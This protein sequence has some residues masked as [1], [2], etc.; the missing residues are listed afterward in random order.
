MQTILIYGLVNNYYAR[1]QEIYVTIGD[2]TDV[3][4]NTICASGKLTNSGSKLITDG[5]MWSCVGTGMYLGIY[6]TS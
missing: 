2:K 5:G 1:I 3:T 4:Q 6:V